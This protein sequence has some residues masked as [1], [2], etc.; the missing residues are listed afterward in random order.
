VIDGCITTGLCEMVL[1]KNTC[2]FANLKLFNVP[3]P[4]VR[5]QQ[6]QTYLENSSRIVYF[7]ET[8]IKVV[9]LS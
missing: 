9:I 8:D 1:S 3:G 7:R 5:K 4:C 2:R 6:T